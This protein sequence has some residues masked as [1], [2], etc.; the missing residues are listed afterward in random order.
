MMNES[1]YIEALGDMF[2]NYSRKTNQTIQEFEKPVYKIIKKYRY[3]YNINQVL[4]QHGN[5]YDG[6]PIDVIITF[7]T[8]NFL[9]MLIDDFGLDPNRILFYKKCDFM[10]TSIALLR[11]ADPNKSDERGRTPL[12]ITQNPKIARLLLNYKAC[13]DLANRNGETPFFYHMKHQRFGMADI[14]LSYSN[15]DRVD[16]SGFTI[17]ECICTHGLVWDGDRSSYEDLGLTWLLRRGVK[18]TACALYLAVFHCNE[19]NVLHLL[20]YGAPIPEALD[21]L[22]NNNAVRLI[23]LLKNRLKIYR[24]YINKWREHAKKRKVEREYLMAHLECLPCGRE[25]WNARERCM[26]DKMKD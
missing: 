13:P 10:C 1:Q 4:F 15:I 16:S 24:K 23:N 20:D 18:P 9:I 17:L 12:H 3:I 19:I 6:S 21:R 8:Y 2:A 14:L 22:E 25:W 26:N 5:I 7:D 11:G